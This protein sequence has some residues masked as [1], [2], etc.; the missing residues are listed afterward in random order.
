MP[1]FHESVQKKTQEILSFWFATENKPKWFIKDQ[2]FDR[3]VTSKFLN[4][5]E[6]AAKEEDLDHW[7]ESLDGSLALIILL[8]QFPRNMFRGDPRSFATDS[9]A[10]AITKK[11]IA[12]NIDHQASEDYKHFLYMPLMHS[13]DLA[14]QELSVELF[15]YNPGARDYA[16]RHMEIIKRFGRFPHRNIILG[17]ESTVEEIQ[18]LTTPGSSF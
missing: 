2:E 18:F 4:Y 10:I 7:Q 12:Q 16:I 1:K 13:E 8:D 15:S 14:D 9:R 3:E 17:R 11:I 5:Y 6:E